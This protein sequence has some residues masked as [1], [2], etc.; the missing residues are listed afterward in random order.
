MLKSIIA[1]KRAKARAEMDKLVGRDKVAVIVNPENGY[2]RR[3]KLDGIYL[4]SVIDMVTILGDFDNDPRKYW[5]QHKKRFTKLD[6]EL[7]HHIR[8][9]KMKS[10][11]DKSYLTDVAPL[12]D[13]LMIASFMQTPNSIALMRVIFN[14]WA[15][16]K[17]MSPTTRYRLSNIEKG[18]EWSADTI[19]QYLED[20]DLFDTD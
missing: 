20:N 14:E 6:P 4:Y 10:S 2:V 8:Q 18:L 15:G 11:D 3:T 12:V 7:S 16:Q 19:H 5:A 9:L 17:Y 13:C 1:Q